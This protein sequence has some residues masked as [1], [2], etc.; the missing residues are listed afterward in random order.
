MEEREHDRQNGEGRRREGTSVSSEGNVPGEKR[1]TKPNKID[2]DEIFTDASYH[3]GIFDPDLILSWTPREFQN[4]IKGAQL[5]KIDQ[6]D[7][8]AKTAM[9][10]R[11]AQHAKRANA[12]KIFNA[13][14]ARRNLEIGIKGTDK[15]VERM[16]ALN[17]KFQGF[18]PKFRP[19]GG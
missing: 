13:D 12:R 9:A 17:K 3:L 8:M 16:I 18:K 11:Y 1:R 5:K 15:N 4:F 14:Q 19:K 10:N 2:Y 7:L 6:Y